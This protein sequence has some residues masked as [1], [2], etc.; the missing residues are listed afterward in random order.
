M[1]IEEKNLMYTYGVATYSESESEKCYYSQRE[2]ELS[3]QQI[4]N[5][6]EVLIWV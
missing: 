4:Y 6:H 1:Q 5:K 3:L 2:I